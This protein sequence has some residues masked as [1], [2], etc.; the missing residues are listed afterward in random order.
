[1]R[2]LL[3]TLSAATCLVQAQAQSGRK[4][5]RI[6]PQLDVP[7]IAASSMAL[8][9]GCMRQAVKS[10]LTTLDIDRMSTLRIPGFDRVALRVDPTRQAQAQSISDNVRN[11]TIVAP[12]LL[13][14][15]RNV[16]KEWGG[17][18][19]L[20]VEQAT[21]T[22][23]LQAWSCTLAGRYRPIAYIPGATFEQRTDARNYNSFYSGHTASTASA[24][25]FMAKVL[26][27]M[28]PELGGK[29]WWLYAAATV[30][31]AVVGYYRVEAGK[32]FPSDVITGALIGAATGWLVPELHKTV[33]GRN[34]TLMPIASKGTLG[35][36]V[37]VWL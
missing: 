11:V 7:V 10:P 2:T 26:D 13:V 22:A 30:P 29:R 35:V 1:M 14:L 24:A 31:T 5:Y 9:T 18:L 23:G 32:H 20:Y 19:T 12:L 6:D 27:D 16:R 37:G 15:D 34:I 21:V 3:L 4:V 17:V 36:H 25:F 28:H 33:G 8:Y